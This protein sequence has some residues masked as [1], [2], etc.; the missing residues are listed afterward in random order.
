MRS[1][2]LMLCCMLWLAMPATADARLKAETSDPM[3]LL[4]EAKLTIADGKLAHAQDLLASIELEAAED[5]VRQEVIFQRMMLSASILQATDFLLRELVNGDLF[6][7]GYA[8]YLVEERGRQAA[9]FEETAR[10]FIELTQEN[11]QLEFVRFRLPH[12]TV[13]HL[14]D[15]DLYSDFEMLSAASESWEK[16]QQRLGK[17]LVNA[18]ARVALVLACARYYDL[19][20]AS[21][22]IEAVSLRLLEGVPVS[23]PQTVGWISE[24]AYSV[25]NPAD[26]LEELSLLADASLNPAA[27]VEQTPAAAE[28]E[29]GPPPPAEGRQRRMTRGN[30]QSNEN[31]DETSE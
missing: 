6:E 30:K 23:M 9:L 28:T 22:T 2:L 4:E 17:G 18:Q 19:E 31:D 27:Q 29:M 16:D 26:G 8:D 14:R 20:E 1:C 25:A 11:P 10:S 15:V 3:V 12:V 24:F 13:E 7:S 5:Y 21:A